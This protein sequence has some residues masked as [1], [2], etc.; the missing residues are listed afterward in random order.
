MKPVI[1]T[2]AEPGAAGTLARLEARGFTALNAATARI[3]YR[4][5]QLDLGGVAALA[6]TSPN[7]VGAFVHNCDRRDLPAMTVGAVTAA[8]ARAAGFKSVTSADG[9]GAALARLIAAAPPDGPVLHVC[10]ADQAFSLA[11]A[12]AGRGVTADTQVLYEAVETGGLEPAVLAAL[13]AGAVILVHS[14]LGA[15]R[16]AARVEE[17]G[18]RPALTRCDVAAISAKAAAPLSHTPV[19]RI[20]SADTPDEDAL[21]RVLDAL[22]A[23]ARR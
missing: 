3:A 10:G 17:A 9:D 18:A 4:D 21:F 1:V 20:H 7:G 5:M 15:E 14:P 12:L 6:F 23:Q 8:A 13:E 22:V 11:E 2:R 19:R 16:F